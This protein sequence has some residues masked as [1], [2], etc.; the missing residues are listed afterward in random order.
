VLADAINGDMT[1]FNK[2]LLTVVARKDIPS[3]HFFAEAMLAYADALRAL[4]AMQKG[5]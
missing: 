1:T 4:A 2:A 3:V 5:G